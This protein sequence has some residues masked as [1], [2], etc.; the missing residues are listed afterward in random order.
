MQTPHLHCTY[1]QD[2]FCL[3]EIQRTYYKL[4]WVTPLYLPM[5]NTA[6]ELQAYEDKWME[7]VAYVLTKSNAGEDPSHITEY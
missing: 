2:H 3:L 5:N 4:G 6:A 1:I 7:Q